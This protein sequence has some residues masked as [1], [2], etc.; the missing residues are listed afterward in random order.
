MHLQL[1]MNFPSASSDLEK[2]FLIYTTTGI[3]W[4]IKP[5]QYGGWIIK[6]DMV[7]PIGMVTMSV[8]WGTTHNPHTHAKAFR[9]TM[10]IPCNHVYIL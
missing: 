7:I 9:K 2:I 5:I 8:V 4:N 1:L 3:Y 6:Q 10:F